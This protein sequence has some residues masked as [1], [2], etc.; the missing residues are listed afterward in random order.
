MLISGGGA[1]LAGIGTLISKELEIPVVSLP[2][3]EGYDDI[4]IQTQFPIVFGTMLSYIH[5]KK[6]TVNF[7][8][9]E[10]VPDIASATRKIYY[11]AFTFISLTLLVFFIKLISSMILTA[12]SNS[13]YNDILRKNFKSYFRKEAGKDPIKQANSILKKKKKDYESVANLISEDSSVLELLKEILTYWEKD[14]SFDLR[15]LTI[16]E[17]IIRIDGSIGSSKA[18]DQFKEKLNQTKKFD[19]VTLNIRYT[20]KNEVPFTMTIKKKLKK[21]TK[22]KK[23]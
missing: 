15:N 11:L 4:K 5:S 8:K 9:G 23:K 14:D 18:I 22:K 21:D 6:S 1:N 19:S 17:R 3:V 20:R 10:F 16:N 2:F 7:L 12:R 13:Y